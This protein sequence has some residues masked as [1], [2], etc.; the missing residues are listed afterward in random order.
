MSN[1]KPCGLIHSS[2][3]FE[4]INPEELEAIIDCFGANLLIFL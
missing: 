1:N 3:N 4:G 2:C